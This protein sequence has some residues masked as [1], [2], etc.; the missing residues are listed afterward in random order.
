MAYVEER[1][2]SVLGAAT[3]MIVLS[4]LLF[5]IPVVG[6][7]IAGFVGGHKAGSVSNALVAA[8]LP[9]IVLA[10]VVFLL[11]TLTGAPVVGALAGVGLLLG[12]VL[13][14]GPLFLGALLG[15]VL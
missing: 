12:I 13:H 9:A 10:V 7:L 3:W 2:G 8:A 4:I 14:S 1:R 15:A 6:P 11:A 5:W